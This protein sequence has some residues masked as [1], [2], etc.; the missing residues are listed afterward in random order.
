VFCIN[1]T[2]LL[3]M[4]CLTCF[5]FPVIDE[6]IL[7]CTGGLCADV[8]SPTCTH[9]VVEERLV[10]TLPADIQG[11]PMV[12]RSEVTEIITSCVSL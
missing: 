2:V 3:D 1:N 8:G 12:V 6:V 11:R 4:S 5:S 10:K 9:L 7:H